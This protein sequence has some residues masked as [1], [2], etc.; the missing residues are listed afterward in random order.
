MRGL[1]IAATLALSFTCFDTARAQSAFAIEGGFISAFEDAAF[2]FGVR[3]TQV[4]PGAI[5]VDFALA[6][7]PQA[8]AEGVFILLPNLDLTTPVPVGPR[9]WLEPRIG[10][11][12]LVGAGEAAGA[13]P[14]FNVG[15]GLLGR[16]GEK[17]GARLD[18]SYQRYLSGGESLG[19]TAVTF[20]VAWLQ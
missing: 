7:L 10:V 15:I 17:V 9:A 13:V 14:G 8:I 1:I 18:V 5:G 19:F 4:K 3:L 6:T 16:M 11:S 20:G 12:A 2:L